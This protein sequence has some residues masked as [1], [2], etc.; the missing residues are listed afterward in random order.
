MG[1][2][3]ECSFLKTSFFLSFFAFVK[4]MESDF[5]QYLSEHP[6]G[7]NFFYAYRWLLV[8]FKRGK[9]VHNL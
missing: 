4:V 1:I 7:D 3:N 2:W 5:Y 9:H 8:T 6:M